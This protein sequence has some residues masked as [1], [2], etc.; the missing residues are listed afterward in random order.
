[1]KKLVFIVIIVTLPL[2]AFFQFQNFRRFNPPVAYEYAISDE[3][4]VNYYNQELV[5]EYFAKAVEIGAFA[6]L[7]WRNEGLDVRFPDEGNQAD[8]NAASYWNELTARVQLLERKLI[9][10][11]TLKATGHTNQEVRIAE[12][13]FEVANLDLLKDQEGIQ[14]IQVG[15]QSRYVWMVQKQL[16][17]KGYEHELD[18]LFGDDTQ[19]AIISFQTDQGIYPEGLINEETFELL[20]LK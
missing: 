15:G 14:G 17:K 8:V 1:M 6:R 11:N 16:I 12:S 19:N 4:D 13:G 2:I 20:F 10:S 18:G 9:F 7:K 3:V 5:D